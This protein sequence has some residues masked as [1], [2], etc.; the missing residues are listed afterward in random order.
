MKLTILLP[1]VSSILSSTK[2]WVTKCLL[3]EVKSD[4]GSYGG[5]HEGRVW[6]NKF[7]VNFLDNKIATKIFVL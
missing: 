5:V 4:F 1:I 6:V 2:I 7:F 3:G